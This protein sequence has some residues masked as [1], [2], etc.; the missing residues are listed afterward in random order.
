[1]TSDAAADA[2][3]GINRHL[4]VHLRTKG[5]MSCQREVGKSTANID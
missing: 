5:N 1:M 2:M 4:S 3:L